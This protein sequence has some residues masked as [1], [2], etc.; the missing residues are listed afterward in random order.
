M[1][2][3]FE[4]S[5]G[6]KLR[7]LRMNA[8]KWIDPIW[9]GK[10]SPTR[11]EVYQLV[12]HVL[13]VK[14]F[15]V[16]QADHETLL[17]LESRRGFVTLAFERAW[18]QSEPTADQTASSQANVAVQRGELVDQIDKALFDALFGGDVKR[19]RW[20]KDA[21][22]QVAAERCLTIGAATS[23]VDGAGRRWIAKKSPL[24]Q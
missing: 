19:R 7:A 23:T 2:L 11:K 9:R 5:G 15:H 10:T 21:G 20:P 14:R 6:P 12:G 18:K 8:H 16:A 4:L 17:R 24:S 3:T 13:G 22:G 1:W